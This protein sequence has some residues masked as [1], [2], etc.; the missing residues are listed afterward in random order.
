MRICILLTLGLL[1]SVGLSACSGSKAAQQE[2][3]D[4]ETEETETLSVDAFMRRLG[5]E[6]VFY[7]PEGPARGDISGVNGQRFRLN[8]R[9]VVDVYALA[10][11]TR[12]RDEANSLV[13]RLSRFD[14]HQRSNLV[15]IRRT[16]Q[17]PS[18]SG[19]L[20]ALLGPR[21]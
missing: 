13:M 6:G 16:Q 17:D 21:L 9:D 1:L 5:A 14:I 15:V 20:R 18:V 12:A 7:T 4:G 3:A 19:A 8:N 11:E 10:T 2:P